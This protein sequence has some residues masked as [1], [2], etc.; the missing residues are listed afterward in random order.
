MQEVGS[1]PGVALKNSLRTNAH[2]QP[3]LHV[4]WGNCIE[5]AKE[6]RAL[7]DP[8]KHLFGCSALSSVTISRSPVLQSLA[9]RF[10]GSSAAG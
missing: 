8:R 4:L 10:S 2:W 3:Y 1:T 5:N 7:I 9:L 6:S